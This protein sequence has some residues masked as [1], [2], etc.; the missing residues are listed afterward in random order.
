MKRSTLVLSVA[1]CALP[2]VAEA[3]YYPS[4]S[5][6]SDDYAAAL[7]QQNEFAAR[8]HQ[9]EQMQELERRQRDLEAAQFQAQKDAAWAEQQRIN[10]EI[11]RRSQQNV[12]SWQ[13]SMN[14]PQR[15]NYPFYD[16]PR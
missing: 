16:P 9:E 4:Y 15:S 1:L 5:S 3:Q 12:D 10:D 2:V 6:P 13:R 14:P 8:Q 7:R 11:N